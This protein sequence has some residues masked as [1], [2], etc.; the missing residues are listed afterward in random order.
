[1]DVREIVTKY[2]M[3][4]I[5]LILAVTSVIGGYYYWKH[6]IVNEALNKQVE[7]IE[8]KSKQ[9]LD[10][11]D[12]EIAEKLK[13]EQERNNNAIQIYLKHGQDQ[14]AAANSAPKQLFIRTKTSCSRDSMLRG[15]ENERGTPSGVA[16]I[17][18][19]ELP[20]GNLQRLNEALVKIEKMQLEFELLLNSIP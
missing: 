2:A 17:G 19:T 6:T 9:L 11:K 5:A 8:R 14:L 4:I 16:G 1:M 10:R 18:Q 7:S 15:K 20:A 3:Q 12:R 13:R